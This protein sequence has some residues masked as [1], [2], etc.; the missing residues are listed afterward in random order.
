MKKCCC[1]ALVPTV[2][3]LT[4]LRLT[5]RVW[6]CVM[7]VS[8]TDWARNTRQVIFFP[9]STTKGEQNYFSL[10]SDFN[11]LRL[12]W[13]I[14]LFKSRF[15]SESLR[16]KLW[17][18]RQSIGHQS[19][20]ISVSIKWPISH[21]KW[22]N[23]LGVYSENSE[24]RVISFVFSVATTGRRDVTSD[25][26]RD[27]FYQA[28]RQVKRSGYPPAHSLWSERQLFLCSLNMYRQN[29]TLF[30][31]SLTVSR[32]TRCNSHDSFQS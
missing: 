27:T 15:I 9:T 14:A 23:G 18:W 6:T 32:G 21:F 1:L 2:T 10:R 17:Q 11:W 28:K 3:F 7:W 8:S 13:L 22:P 16:V 31:Q 30:P 19:L 12:R 24:T 26:F 5:L 20:I 4:L 25:G 29:I